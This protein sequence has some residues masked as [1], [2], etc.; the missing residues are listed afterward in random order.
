MNIEQQLETLAEQ[1]CVSVHDVRSMAQMVCNGLTQDKVADV[2]V[3]AENAT[4]VEMAQA[5]AVSAASKAEKIST[6][7]L[8]RGR[9]VMQDAVLGLVME[10][11]A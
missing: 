5:Y 9:E 7:Y 8:T 3:S 2:Y 4:Q 1:M 6:I 11:M 10:K